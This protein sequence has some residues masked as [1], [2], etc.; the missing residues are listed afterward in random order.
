MRML[1]HKY[2]KD[3]NATDVLAFLIAEGPGGITGDIV[4]STQMARA[5]AKTFGSTA[6]GELRLYAVHGMLH[7]C[8][9]EDKTAPARRAMQERALRVLNHVNP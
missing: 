1:H 3:K 9:W 5:N 2:L 4:I 6:A 7:L 8:G